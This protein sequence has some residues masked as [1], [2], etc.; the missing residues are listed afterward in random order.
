M[1]ILSY[2][3]TLCLAGSTTAAGRPAVR[4]A[5]APQLP[6]PRVAERGE[7]VAVDECGR[8]GGATRR[9]SS[10]AA[11]SR[12]SR[13]RTTIITSEVMMVVGSGLSFSIGY[14]AVAVASCASECGTLRLLSS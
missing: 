2:V 12:V 3:E 11:V 8:M 10:T 14:R 7:N 6:L 13:V 9:P 5:G 4:V 1:M